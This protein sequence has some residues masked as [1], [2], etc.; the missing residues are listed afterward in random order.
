MS[1]IHSYPS[2]F[3]SPLHSLRVMLAA[4]AF[5]Y[6]ASGSGFGEVNLDPLAAEEAMATLIQNHASQGRAS[7]THNEVLQFVARRKAEDMAQ[8]GYFAHVDPDGFAANFI[9]GQAG[10]HLPYSTAPSVNSIESIGVQHQNG[11]TAAAA[12]QIVFDAWLNSP[13]HRAHVLA[14]NAGYAAQ[15]YYA[16]G[17]AFLAS[18]PFGFNSHYFVFVSAP[19]DPDASFGSYPQWRFDTLTLQQMNDPLEDADE[20]GISNPFEYAFDTDPLQP[21][22]FP[23]A[24]VQLDRENGQFRMAFPFRDDLDPVLRFW[25]EES[26]GEGPGGFWQWRDAAFDREGNEFVVTAGSESKGFF[27]LR[28]ERQ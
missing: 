1:T 6:G 25:V 2:L 9:A 23:P 8:R 5:L 24:T 17:Y 11:L 16:V 21:H 26:D 7:M 22:E 4:L 13:G 10:Y 3:K 12:A 20:D 15:T 14:E 18:G 19:P 28:T 27:R